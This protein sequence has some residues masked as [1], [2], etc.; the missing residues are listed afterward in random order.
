MS[1]RPVRRRFAEHTTAED[2]RAYMEPF[3]RNL[4]YRFN[5]DEEFVAEVLASEIE[6]LDA[7]GDVFCPC[8]VRTGDPKEDVTI[9]CP[10]IPFYA[11]QFAKLQ[12]CWCGLFVRTDVKDGSELHGVVEV[13]EGPAEVPVALMAE[14]PA[15]TLRTVRIGKREIALARIG[16]EFFALGNVCRHAFG[17]LGQGFLEGHHAVCPWHGWRFDV[18]DGTTDHPGADVA[19]YATSVRDGYVFVTV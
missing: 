15:G 11:D 10:C 12:K 17:P 7:A 13:P 14:F 5:D 4:G 2:L 8:R 3:V 9:V 16:D 1:G 18:R 19:T 6:I